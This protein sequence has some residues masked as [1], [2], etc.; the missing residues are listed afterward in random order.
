MSENSTPGFKIRLDDG[1]DDHEETSKSSSETTDA[2]PVKKDQGPKPG[3]NLTWLS[4]ILISL[5]FLALVFGYFNILGKLKTIYTSGSEETQH[6][7]KDLESKFS[8]LAVKLSN[9]EAALKDLTE[10]HAGLSTSVSSLKDDL[11]K[12]NKSI[13]GISASKA[14][15]KSVS[16]SVATIDKKLAS[17]E[18]TIHENTAD[19]AVLSAELKSIFTELNNVS[20]KSSEDLNSVK[21][22]LDAVQADKASKKDLLTE[23]DHIENVLKTNQAKADKQAASMLQSIQRIDMRT[24][25]L[26]VKAGL[27]T[28]S[29]G[30]APVNQSESGSGGSSTEQRS[31]APKPGEL[32]ERDISH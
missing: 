5:V 14:D 9:M 18:K 19:R 30:F 29:D 10:S 31:S 7:S 22:L 28:P 32:I 1:T 25:A 20:V 2:V 11:A 3:R 16:S 17:I 12:A 23:I 21:A 4:Y 8:S 26:E 6:L 13:S 15:K 27:P 24:N